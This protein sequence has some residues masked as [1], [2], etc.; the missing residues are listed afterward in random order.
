MG[1][2]LWQEGNGGDGKEGLRGEGRWE[3]WEKGGTGK[4]GEGGVGE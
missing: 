3:G 2:A 4:E 1:T